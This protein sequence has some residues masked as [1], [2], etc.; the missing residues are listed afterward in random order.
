VKTISILPEVSAACVTS[1]SYHIVGKFHDGL[2][3][4]IEGLLDCKID[5]HSM[6]SIVSASPHDM[7]LD[8]MKQVI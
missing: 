6:Y 4:A 7:I 3:K 1:M 2:M 8:S 5:E